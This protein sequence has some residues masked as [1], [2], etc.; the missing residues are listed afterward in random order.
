MLDK[1]NIW[2]EHNMSSLVA[3][4]AQKVNPFDPPKNVIR[5]CKNKRFSYVTPVSRICKQ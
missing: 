4:T 5:L 1:V 2:S 3:T